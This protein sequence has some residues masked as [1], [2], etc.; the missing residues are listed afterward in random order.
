MQVLKS[1]WKALAPALA[2]VWV[3]ALAV[4][5]MGH[6]KGN[7]LRKP[8]QCKS[9]KKPKKRAACVACVKRAKKHHFHPGKAKGKR[10]RP[11]NGKP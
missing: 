1:S 11:N 8:A 4:P 3:L 9:I 2:F 7:A 5:A 10:C 6:G